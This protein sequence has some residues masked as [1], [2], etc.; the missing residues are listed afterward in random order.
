[1]SVHELLTGCWAIPADKLREIR[2]IYAMHVRGETPDIAAIEARMGRPLQGEKPS[3]SILAGGVGLIEASGT[4]APKAN[5]MMEFS[6]GI[7]A[8]QLAHHVETVANDN[9]ARSILLALDSPG[10]NVLGIP[11]AADAVYR[12]SQKKPV[13]VLAS[14]QLTSAGY[15]IGSAASAVYVTG[16]VVTV[17]SIGVL[18]SRTFDPTSPK[19]EEVITAGKYKALTRAKEPLSA[20]AR[21]LVQS[22]VDYVYSL[23]V[24][25]V[26]RNRG[27]TSAA[28]LENMA[29]GRVFRGQQAIDAG[30]VDG[31]ST[32]SDLVALMANQPEQFATRRKA[33]FASRPSAPK[34]AGARAALDDKTSPLPQGNTMEPITRESLQADH[35][36]LFNALQTEFTAAGAAA[37]RDRIKAV[38]ATVVP[39]HEELVERLAM[40]GKTTAGEAALAVNAAV[41]EAHTAAAAAHVAEAP[42]AIKPSAAPV[43]EARKTKEEQVEA[44]KAYAAEHNVDFV[45]ACKALKFG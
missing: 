33:V 23:F 28:V 15:W 3:H 7:S 14:E 35:A 29:E 22:D 12:A 13:V 30:L 27:T 17:G 42:G 43:L 45:A 18:V 37:E 9:G 25:Q 36:P 21:Q 40:D 5:M 2:A 8:Q 41:R 4:L 31:I 26:A 24:D 32:F 10:G 38:R 11:E 44:A 6:G 39:G 1:M 19:V 16:P 34:S 20:D